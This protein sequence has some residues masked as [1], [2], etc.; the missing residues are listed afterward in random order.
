MKTAVDLA[1]SYFRP[2][3]TRGNLCNPR[4]NKPRRQRSDWAPVGHAGNRLKSAFLAI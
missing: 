1:P 2:D 4:R 3:L